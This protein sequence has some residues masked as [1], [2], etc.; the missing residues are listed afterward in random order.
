MYWPFGQHLL[1]GAKLVRRDPRLFAVYLTNHGC[2]PDTMVS[3]LFAEEMGDKPYLHIEM[4]EHF[5]Q[6]GIITRIEA[7][8][9]ALDNYQTKD[10]S[11]R[12]QATKT[13]TSGHDKLDRQASAALLSV[14]PYGPLVGE[15]L[16]RQGA[17]VSLAKMGTSQ[18]LSV[19]RAEVRSK[20]YYSFVLA[21]GAVLQAVEGNASDN[22]NSILSEQSSVQQILMPSS[23][24]AEADG[25]Y[26]RVVRSILDAKGYTNVRLIAPSLEKL[27]W[28][29]HDT[30][31]LFLMLIAGDLYWAAHY[32]YRSTLM[33]WLLKGPF[34]FERVLEAAKRAKLSWLDQE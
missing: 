9:N 7:F 18:S 4:D 25:V 22:T 31:Q 13:I 14:G 12:P 11:T 29:I 16:A 32:S 24:G 19:G 6:V 5:S 10:E 21:L 33:K 3:H 1:S 28:L 27:P 30:D 20:E 23:E 34:T 8:L 15:W 17:Q 2:G 26:D